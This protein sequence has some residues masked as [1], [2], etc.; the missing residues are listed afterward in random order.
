MSQVFYNNSKISPRILR[1]IMSIIE[2]R[3]KEV[4]EK[5]FDYFSEIKYFC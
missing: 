3:S 4:I 2:S 5:W 1:N